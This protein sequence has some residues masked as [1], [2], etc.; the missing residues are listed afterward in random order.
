MMQ[1]PVVP[2]AT[3]PEPNLRLTPDDFSDAGIGQW[4]NEAEVKPGRTEPTPTEE[5]EIKP[6]EQPEEKPSEA[7]EK[8]LEEEKGTEPEQ[9]EEPFDESS[10]TP[11]QK[12]E[13][14]KLKSRNAELE[15]TATEAQT[16]STDLEKRLTDQGRKLAA[17]QKMVEGKADA[18]QKLLEFNRN[19]F[20]QKY[21]ETLA[22]YETWKGTAEQ[23]DEE[24][25]RLTEYG[26]TAGATQAR[27][28]AAEHRKTAYD[29]HKNAIEMQGNFKS[30]ER[31]TIFR[32]ASENEEILLENFPEFKAV[33]AKFE[34][35]CQ[36]YQMNP[37]L[38]KGN[39]DLMQAIYSDLLDSERGSKEAL[40][41]ITEGAQEVANKAAAR[42]KNAGAPKP[43]G[44]SRADT[45]ERK[46]WTDGLGRS[47]DKRF[48]PEAI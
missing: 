10:L 23:W 36:R 32:H 44:G 15:G 26:D 41:K 33:Q 25:K 2:K 11:A 18:H 3:P 40:T 22:D 29:H 20:N 21:A 34:A 13:Y 19:D 48:N 6:E 35:R 42:Q 46:D 8:K 38:I 5:P 4:A 28:M 27:A 1:E 14:D 30:W 7:P 45:R 17:A 9:E 12:R 47:K 16:R 37:L 39:M 43:G 24:A 31:S